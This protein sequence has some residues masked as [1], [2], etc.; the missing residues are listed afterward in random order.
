MKKRTPI[1]RS[2]KPLKRTPIRKVSAKRAKE[3]KQY[4]V[5]RE[6]LLK[7][8]PMCD[9]YLILLGLDR[10]TIDNLQAIAVIAIWQGMDV[11]AIPAGDKAEE[12]KAMG[13]PAYCPRSFDCHHVRG[14]NKYYLDVT[15]FLAVSR[16]CHEYIHQNPS[17]ARAAG[18]L[19]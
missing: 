9:A 1:K 11:P 16:T 5:L 7:H 13:I 8:R 14:R 18:L 4:K 2:R 15:S 12:F 19:K 10:A 6:D 17:A 3:M